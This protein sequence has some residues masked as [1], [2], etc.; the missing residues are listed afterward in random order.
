MP[1]SIA[2]FFLFLTV[3]VAMATPAR[4]QHHDHSVATGKVGSVHFQTSC[5]AEAQPAF[6]RAVAL[7]HSF[8][9]PYAI[10]GFES[11]L[12][13]DPSCA[14]A[15][16]GIAMS[17]W[18][19][20]FSPSPRTPAVLQAGATAVAQARA[21][22]AKTPREQGYVDAVAK[23]FTDA[24]TIDHRTRVVAY[25]DAMTALAA[26]QPADTEATIF[27]ALS[28]AAAAPPADKTY[29]DQLKAG[30]MLE[31]LIAAQPDHPGLAHYIIHAYDVPP[32]ADRALAA[33]R[34][35][36][37]I[38]PVAPHALHM[39]SHT[40]TR[41]GAWQESIDTNIA[42]G[43]AARRE[44]SAS[45]E[46]HA[47][48]YRTYAYLQTAQDAAARQMVD[49]LPEIRTRFDATRSGSAAPSSTSLFAFAAI[50]A[51]FALERGDWAAAAAL[52]P[53]PSPYAFADAVTWY[54]KAIGA[55]RSGDA[56]G[57]RAAMDALA[58]LKAKLVEQKE[59]YWAEQAEIQ[60]SAAAAWLAFV[61]GRRD[62]GLTGL[63]AAAD[64]EDRTEKAAVTPGPLMPAREQVGD[65]LLEMK[66]PAEALQAFEA[67]LKKEPNRFR[68]LAGAS[69]AAAL[70]GDTAKARRY[71]DDLAKICVKADGPVRPELAEARKLAAK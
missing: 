60:R 30:T 11:V 20:P 5:R 49:A 62:E 59:T 55:A 35:Y 63:R 33:A 29:A 15:A 31:G 24:A 65:M 46:L 21:L 23:L 13:A 4:A 41:V 16:W 57:T 26:A 43:D 52:T 71:G 39:P 28:L 25:R 48:D 67:T 58:G 37:T 44:G 18:G 1:R 56:A 51:R 38:A 36:A 40:F 10:E 34:R 45:E 14:M 69:R 54:A 19:N 68:A 70:A 27:A 12:K 61:E 32:L 47:L 7:L 3:T 22:G 6:D 53:Q 64:L 8:E 66:R 50:P 17:R 9:F 42:S 2:P